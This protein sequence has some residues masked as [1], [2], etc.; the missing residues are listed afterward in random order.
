MHIF[1]AP[2]IPNGKEQSTFN[3]SE[4]ESRHCIKVLRLKKDDYLNVT[5]GKGELYS[6][7][8]IDDNVNECSIQIE[9]KIKSKVNK[10]CYIHIAIAPPKKLDRFEWFC[11]KVTEV[12]IDEI[13]PIITY[14]SERL[15]IKNDRINKILISSLKQSQQL[16]LPILNSVTS[17]E[18]CLKKAYSDQKFIGYYH[19]E[20]NELIKISQKGKKIL[21][22]IGPEGDFTNDEVN[23]AKKSGFIPINLGQNR[24]RVE[25]AGL[26]ACQ[27]I[28][29]KNQI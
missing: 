5:N 17:F 29:F 11:E 9:K 20:N 6:A 10:K 13:T 21:V 15:K 19:D 28:I 25:T 27:T 26:T 23:R 16:Q 12:G 24:L 2:Q 1:Y 8:L 14:R 18:D 3:L 7:I 22:L 4:E